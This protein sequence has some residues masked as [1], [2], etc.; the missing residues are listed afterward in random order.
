MGNKKGGLC[1]GLSELLGD[2][3][4]VEASGSSSLSEIPVGEIEPN[5]SQPRKDFDVNAMVELSNS[6]KQIGVITPITLRKLDDHKYQIIAGERR[7]RATQMAGKMTIPA[8]ICTADDTQSAEMALIENIQR[9][10]LN[11]IEVALS[12]KNLMEKGNYTHEQL[13]ERVGKNRTTVSNYLRLLSLP[14]EIQ[15][16]LQEHKIENGHA[17]ALLS[18]DNAAKQEEVYALILKNGYSVRKV[19]EIARNLKKGTD[20]PQK[21]EKNALPEEYSQLQTKLQDTF[22][23]KVDMARNVKG[24]GK[25]TISFSSDKEL[26]KIMEVFDSIMNK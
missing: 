23:T 14:G 24:K 25:I 13:S 19:E 8:Y 12:Y 22:N 3:N 2:I 10:D 4:E 18:I 26:E 5:P 20:T 21:T 7:F 1:R 9:A 16:G 11:A 15:L 17:R 6:I